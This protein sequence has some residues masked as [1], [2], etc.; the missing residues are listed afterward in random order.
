LAER[1]D[2]MN[3]WSTGQIIT[4]ADAVL[5]A[6][7]AQLAHAKQ[8]DIKEMGGIPTLMDEFGIPFDLADKGAYRSGDFWTHRAWRPVERREPVDL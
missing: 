5:Q 1:H 4:G 7:G 2:I 6:F 8:S 3:D